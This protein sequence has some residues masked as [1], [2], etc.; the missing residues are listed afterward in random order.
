[1]PTVNGNGKADSSFNYVFP[2]IRGIQAGREY[3]ITM[4]PL[5]LVPKIFAP[6]DGEIPATLRAQRSLNKSRVPEITK[7]ILENNSDYI[8]SS[9]TASIDGSVKFKAIGKND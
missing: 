8:F 2:A 7:Y 1:M 6:D 3:Y 5:K 4:C 9:L